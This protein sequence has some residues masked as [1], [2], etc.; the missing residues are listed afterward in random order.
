MPPPPP[1]WQSFVCTHKIFICGI[2]K[3]GNSEIFPDAI[4]LMILPGFQ[5]YSWRR[6]PGAFFF[7]PNLKKLHCKNA[8]WMLCRVNF[9]SEVD[10]MVS[11]NPMLLKCMIHVGWRVPFCTFFKTKIPQIFFCFVIVSD[12]KCR[13]DGTIFKSCDG[14]RVS[15]L[16]TFCISYNR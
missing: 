15:F 4:W 3:F 5:S 8:E 10:T 13:D 6:E 7:S 11:S 14:H 16:Q 1:S 2:P 12:T 9:H